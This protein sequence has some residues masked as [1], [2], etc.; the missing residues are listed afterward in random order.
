MPSFDVVSEV[1]LQEVDNAVN[2]ACR[3][4]QTRYDFKGSK[5]TLSLEK[6]GLILVSDNEEKMKSVIDVLQSK[7]IRRGLSLKSLEMGK[8]EAAGG[9]TVRC[10]IKIRQGIEKEKAREIVKTIKNM[11]T[12][13]QSAIEGDKLRISAK[14]KDDL[15]EVIQ[16]LK[17]TDFDVPLQF[18]NFRD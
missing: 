4:L 16:F 7:I 3:E 9:Q 14:K 6:D 15:Q 11:K 10:L 1:A 18:N 17:K 8:V 5:S 2:Q 13:V 12:K